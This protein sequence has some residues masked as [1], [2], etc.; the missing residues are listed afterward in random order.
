MLQIILCTQNHLEG[1]PPPPER[2]TSLFPPKLD[3]P[4][5]NSL[6]E[7]IDNNPPPI[8][9]KKSPLQRQPG[10]SGWDHEDDSSDEDHVDTFKDD[11]NVDEELE[12]LIDRD[13]DIEVRPIEN[14][15]DANGAIVDSE[16]ERAKYVLW[17]C[18]LKD[19]FNTNAIHAVCFLIFLITFK[20]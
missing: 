11:D 9:P 5:V 10:H 4:N 17:I 20:P 18:Y 13:E 3:I 14:P 7:N 6:L 8:P 12:K 19:K 2:T 1:P 16:E 15:A